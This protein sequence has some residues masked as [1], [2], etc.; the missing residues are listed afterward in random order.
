MGV[1]E[2]NGSNEPEIHGSN[3]WDVVREFIRAV[4]DVLNDRYV[5]IT[6]AMAVFLWSGKVAAPVLFEGL[7]DMIHAWRGTSP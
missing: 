2:E 1:T 6:C 5:A 7:V 3:V 4:R